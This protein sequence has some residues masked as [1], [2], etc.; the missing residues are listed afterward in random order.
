MIDGKGYSWTNVVGTSYEQMPNPQGGLYDAGVGHTG[1]GYARITYLG[2]CY[3]GMEYIF[4]YTGSEQVFTPT[5]EG[6]YK[7]EVWGAQGGQSYNNQEGKALDG[8]KG[9]YSKGNISLTK[10]D[11]LYIV[12]GGKGLNYSNST[13]Q[14]PVEG[15]YN[16][17]GQ[18][19]NGNSNSYYSKS[20]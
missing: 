9:G 12:V 14:V 10:S 8:G 4:D 13:S 11:L 3:E 19:K 7:L 15:G 5:C 6:N 1:Y 20:I 17:G 18:G 16:G 2:G